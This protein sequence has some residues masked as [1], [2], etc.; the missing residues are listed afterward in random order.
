MRLVLFAF[1]LAIAL[2]YLAGGRLRRLGGLRFRHGWAGLA[3]VAL[4]FLPFDGTPGYLALLAS[5]GLLVFAAV[6][7]RRHPGFALVIAGL[8][9]NFVVIAVNQG[10]P[11]T[12]D[13]IVASDQ[14]ET[15]DDIRDEGGNKHHLATDEDDLLFLADTIGV[16]APV[17]QAISIGDIAAYAGAMWFVV[18]GMRRREEHPHPEVQIAEAPG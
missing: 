10:M 13:A 12:R 8:C 15:L 2:G 9:L 18:A 1:P 5:F 11:V 3:G 7:N 4:Q 14:A 6:A 16:P 17:R